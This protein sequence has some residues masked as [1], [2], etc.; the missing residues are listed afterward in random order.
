ME[1]TDVADQIRERQEIAAERAAEAKKQRF[2]GRAAL[3]IAVLAM[4]LA[5]NQLGADDA[6]ERV[7][8]TNVEVANLWAFFQAK[9]IRQTSNQLAADELE[10]LLPMLPPEAQPE[11]RRKID[12]YRA[13]VARY[14]SEPDK[15]DPTNPLKGE[16]KKELMARARHFEGLREQAQK[17]GLNFDVATA[18]LQIAIVLGSV[19]VL[20]TSR[21]VLALGLAL[22]AAGVA[23]M[24]NG[25]FGWFEL[26][27]G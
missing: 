23:L 11:A 26:P 12:R 16:G 17:Q 4:L 18:A 8:T 1:A 7:V 15:D 14:E 5:I 21:P 24:I 20:A 3:T 25:F 13:T 6:G 19:A 2:R 22:G 9:N 10:V 27:L